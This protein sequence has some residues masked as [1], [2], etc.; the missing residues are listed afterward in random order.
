MFGLSLSVIF[1][2]SIS[3]MKVREINGFY[4]DKEAG[5]LLKLLFEK[6]FFSQL[7]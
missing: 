2:V 7:I 3:F 4:L 1:L 6:E 5:W